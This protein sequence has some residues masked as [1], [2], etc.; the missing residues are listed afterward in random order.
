MPSSTIYVYV[1]KNQQI[2]K[3]FVGE[4]QTHQPLPGWVSETLFSQTEDLNSRHCR[5]QRR[6]VGGGKIGHSNYVP[7]KLS[8]EFWVEFVWL[9]KNKGQNFNVM[10]I[11]QILLGSTED[12]HWIFSSQFETLRYPNLGNKPK[13]RPTWADSCETVAWQHMPAT[14][15]GAWSKNCQKLSLCAKYSRR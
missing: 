3:I 1:K 13:H 6:P 12:F 4:N 14:L 9:E 11:F 2:L 5:A 10:V 15:F 8:D 7:I